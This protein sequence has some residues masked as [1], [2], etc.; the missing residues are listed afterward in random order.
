MGEQQSIMHNEQ[1]IIAD[2][3]AINLMYLMYAKDLAKR[4]P[5]EAIWVLGL[6]APEILSL[7]EM[8]PINLK[9][10]SECGRCLMNLNIPPKS[11]A[12]ATI[13]E[14]SILKDTK[15]YGLNQVA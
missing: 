10:M 13:G 7:S 15:T 5:T 6:S 11:G 1:S 14:L 8:T 12:I 3:A 9:Q 2:L 4:F